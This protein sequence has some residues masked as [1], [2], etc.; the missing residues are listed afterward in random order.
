MNLLFT[1]PLT[2]VEHRIAIIVDHTTPADKQENKLLGGAMGS[3]MLKQLRKAEIIPTEC[4]IATC[5]TSSDKSDDKHCLKLGNTAVCE[6]LIPLRA[7]LAKYE[8]NLVLLVGK[9]A[10]RLAGIDK[11]LHNFRGSLFVCEDLASPFYGFKCLAVHPAHEIVES[12]DKAVF[13]QFDLRRAKSESR[14][15]VLAFPELHLQPNPNFA[16]LMDRLRAIKSGDTISVDIEGGVP[17]PTDKKYPHPKG[18]TCIGIATSPRDAFIV[19][20]WDFSEENAGRI[21]SEFARI[22]MDP[23]IGKILQNSLYDNFVFAWLWKIMLRNVVWDTMLSGWEMFAELPR[24]L[25]TQVSLMT[26][27]PFYK[28]ERTVPDRVTHYTYCLKDAAYTYEIAEVHKRRLKGTSLENFQFNIRLLPAMLYSELRGIN[29][30][31]ELAQQQLEQIQSHRSQVQERLNFLA[32]QP[33]NPNSS[34]QCCKFLYEVRQL[35]K[36]YK[37]DWSTGKQSLTADVKAL[38]YLST[39]CSEADKQVI[40]ALLKY[41]QLEAMRET[42]EITTDADRRVRCSYDL[43]GP[44]TGR[45]ACRTSP[46]KSGAN[47][48]TVMKKLRHLYC[49]DEGYEMFEC[50]LSGADGWTVAVLCHQAGD[51]TMLEDYRFGLKPA[52]IITLMYNEFMDYCRTH[53]SGRLEGFRSTV[54]AM[55]RPEILAATD[56]LPDDWRYNASKVV[57]HGTNYDMKP[58]TM[59]TNLLLQSY[60]KS[61]TP[62][63]VS[64]NDCDILQR[65]YFSRY[66]G[67]RLSQSRIAGKLAADGKLTAAS[68]SIRQFFGRPNDQAVLRS[69]YSHQPQSNTTHA[70]KLALLRLWEDPENWTPQ[71]LPI[72]EPLHQIHDAIMG[73]WP[74]PRRQWAITKL[75]SWFN[76]ELNIDGFKIVIPFEGKYG[77]D[78]GTMPNHL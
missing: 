16:E 60:K 72:V 18:I 5:N 61:G 45:L 47:L 49:A 20:P 30:R 65:L 52:K 43:V 36:Q 54:N 66:P 59:S 34:Q 56:A 57:Q 39:K 27:W 37:K 77:S 6:T 25:G 55:T 38:L 4:L 53:K 9:L 13:L 21:I 23:T 8:P 24:D 44:D 40:I 26:K 15:P 74:V 69:A 12:I 29:Y 22:A 10:L 73:Q 17:D 63:F 64:A 28:D 1:E 11:K 67:I 46:T 7:R 50:D 33:I 3:V 42:L 75:H 35:P 32:G 19:N 71:G 41:R 31:V 76:N 48:T 70:T 58:P 78:W 2:L 51:S 14:S 62:I 68:G